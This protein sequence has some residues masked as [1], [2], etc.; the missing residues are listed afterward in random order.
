[1]HHH[2]RG[3]EDIYAK[4][5]RTSD[6][7]P[8]TD[9]PSSVSSIGV[10]PISHTPL[11]SSH[12]LPNARPMIWWP[13]HA[14]ASITHNIVIVNDLNQA[15]GKHTQHL[16]LRFLLCN[17]PDI[18]NEL[19]YPLNILIRRSSFRFPRAKVSPCRK[20]MPLKH[21]P[22][23]VRMIPSYSSIRSSGGYSIFTTS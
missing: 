7:T 15:R 18:R 9:F 17:T 11:L 8:N 10:G 23:P 13:K 16:N 22:A 2:H 6:S 20:T 1:M 5:T 3:K 12:S 4:H 19:V 14:P 21:A